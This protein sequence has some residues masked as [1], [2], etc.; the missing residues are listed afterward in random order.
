[1][2]DDGNGDIGTMML[3][4]QQKPTPRMWKGGGIH[5]TSRH[6]SK[7]YTIMSKSGTSHSHMPRCEKITRSPC[8]T[9]H[10]VES[11]PPH[12]Y[13]DAVVDYVIVAIHLLSFTLHSCL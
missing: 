3:G 6:A 5:D 10:F 9:E 12:P 8:V 13:K 7:S 11:L 2:R 1:M 4:W